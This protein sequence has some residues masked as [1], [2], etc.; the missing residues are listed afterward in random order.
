MIFL[1]VLILIPIIFVFI[2]YLLF[3][4]FKNILDGDILSKEEIIKNTYNKNVIYLY[5]NI[6]FNIGEDNYD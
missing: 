5:R 1:R 6:Y 3:K 4:I 2:M